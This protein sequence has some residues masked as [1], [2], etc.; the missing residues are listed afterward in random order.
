MFGQ[1]LAEVPYSI[2]MDVLLDRQYNARSNTSCSAEWLGRPLAKDIEG[3][4]ALRLW[5]GGSMMTIDAVRL[6]RREW[7]RFTG[8]TALAVLAGNQSA[9]GFTEGCP[10]CGC[11]VN[12]CD[13]GVPKHLHCSLATTKEKLAIERRRAKLAHA[14]AVPPFLT[15]LC[16]EVAALIARA[17][18]YDGFETIHHGQAPDGRVQYLSADGIYDFLQ[19]QR[20]AREGWVEVTDKE[21]IG[22]RVNAG[23]LVVGVIRSSDMTD[24]NGRTRANGHIVTVRSGTYTDDGRTLNIVDAALGG[25][26]ARGVNASFTLNLAIKRPDIGKMRFYSLKRD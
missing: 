15:T 6:P 20:A 1:R 18:G 26:L 10:L 9:Y 14:F 3:L 4:D 12:H 21:G 17:Y 11:V 2:R 13:D 24:D 23:Q 7:L 22:N 16:N 19:S 25:S 8:I 5:L